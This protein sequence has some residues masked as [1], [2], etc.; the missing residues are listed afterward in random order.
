MCFIDEET[1]RFL[2]FN[3][4]LTNLI[5]EELIGKATKKMRGI[6]LSLENY[7]LDVIFIFE[8][9]LTEEEKTETRKVIEGIY[10][11]VI[12]IVYNY[13]GEPLFTVK[14]IGLT[15]TIVPSNIEINNK[16]ANMGWVYLRKEYS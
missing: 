2:F 10:H 5:M 9:E 15:I 1:R 16:R 13:E 11:K 12:P 4:K 8:S 14:D 6:T 3:D 7:F